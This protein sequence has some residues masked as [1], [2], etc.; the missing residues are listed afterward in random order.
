MK[1][2]IDTPGIVITFN[3]LPVTMASEVYYKV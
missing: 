3:I 1:M 2:R